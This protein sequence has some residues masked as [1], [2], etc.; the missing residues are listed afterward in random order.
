MLACP[1]HQGETSATIWGVGSRHIT[2]SPDILKSDGGHTVAS[3]IPC[4]HET[5][6][7][8]P[9]LR[10]RR[11]AGTPAHTPPLG[12]NETVRP[13][14]RVQS[15]PLRQ[16][17]LNGG[18]LSDRPAPLAIPQQTADHPEH[19]VERGKHDS[20]TCPENDD[21][22]VDDKPFHHEAHGARA[23]A[24]TARKPALRAHTTR[25][26]ERA[27]ERDT[28]AKTHFQS[29]LSRRMGRLVCC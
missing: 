19:P 20:Q 4:D 3:S 10:K 17:P 25:L 18:T 8:M 16:R 7:A 29:N 13:R 24:T 15:R 21:T 12:R 14:N 22:R 26:V 11:G 27:R 23:S 1:P 5:E 9:V 28:V 2:P 6:D